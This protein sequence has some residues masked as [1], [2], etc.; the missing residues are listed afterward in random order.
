MFDDFGTIYVSLDE[1]GVCTLTLNRPQV[2]NAFDD[3]MI[4]DLTLAFEQ[5][6]SND[7]VRV[8]IL[9]GAGKS[10]CA[11][12]DLNWMRK[13]AGYDEEQNFNDAS[14]LATM[15]NRLYRIPRP[16]VGVIHGN[17]FGGG[18]GLVACCDIAIASTNTTL[19]LSEVRLGLVPS[20]ISPYVIEAIGSREARRYFL[21]GERFDAQ[22]A[23]RIGLIQEFVKP[24]N[25]PVLRDQITQALLDGAPYAQQHA[26]SLIQSIRS[27][28]IGEETMDQTARLIARVRASDEGKEGTS[29]FFEK[30]PPSW[31]EPLDE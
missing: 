1:R 4:A 6:Q 16:T 29:A 2:H 7:A 23:C 9:Q 17:V 19:S 30:R 26:K 13:I 28:P 8:L 11:G 24:E 14:R 31:R 12:A 3:S 21:T 5:I 20:V 27:K 10:F 25:L 22:T 15:M 18:T